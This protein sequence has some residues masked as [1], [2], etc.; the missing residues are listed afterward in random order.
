MARGSPTALSLGPGY[1]YIGAMGRVEPTDLIT[2]WASVDLGWGALGSCAD[3]EPEILTRRGWLTH[4]QVIEGDECLGLSQADGIARW[5][6]ILKMNR[7]PAMPQGREMISMT[8][9]G[10]SSL[11]TPN[12]RWLVDRRPTD[13]P[14]LVT[15]SRGRKW[16]RV[17][18]TTEDLL[19]ADHIP[20][21]A[22][23]ANLPDEPKYA[24]A[25]VELL[26]WFVTEGS[27]NRHGTVSVYQ[28]PTANP[29]NCASI[30]A[31]L[32]SLFGPARASMRSPRKAA[33]PAW[34]EGVN[35]SCAV[36]YLNKAASDI[37]LAAAP[38]KMIQPEFV[39]SLTLG[40]LHLL[41]ATAIKG[42]G[43]HEHF[44]SQRSRD[45]LDAFQM[46]ASLTGQFSTLRDIPNCGSP[47]WVLNVLGNRT[48][49]TQLGL[50]Q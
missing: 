19:W 4:D 48:L 27:I 3:A 49:R 43:W 12:H 17:I 26:A 1:L 10:H 24:D 22:P 5:Q 33:P 41:L 18:T 29:G 28:S 21:A 25:F 23:V 44:L 8:S 2:P 31:A 47:N 7:F 45:R 13:K 39:S 15:G 11:T 14:E 16:G 9:W 46:A 38:G 20:V 50:P 32:D 6:P 34:R 42:D 36:F 35:K 30:R 40:Q 37:V